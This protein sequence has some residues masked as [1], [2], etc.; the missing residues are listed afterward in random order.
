MDQLRGMDGS[1]F[2][3]LPSASFSPMPG[4]PP[5]SN[6]EFHDLPEAHINGAAASH[7]GERRR[8]EMLDIAAVLEERYR[9][10]LPPERRHI[11][12]TERLERE[13]RVV[14]GPSASAEP[15]GDLD[16]EIDGDVNPANLAAS[17]KQGDKL[18][19]TSA[20]SEILSTGS[21]KSVTPA[22]FTAPSRKR[23]PTAT[24]TVHKPPPTRRSVSHG[25][26]SPPLSSLHTFAVEPPL[27]TSPVQSSPIRMPQTEISLSASPASPPKAMNQRKQS[28]KAEAKR[29]NK[30]QKHGKEPEGHKPTA[31]SIESHGDE[32]E[33]KVTTEPATETEDDD[34]EMAP[35]SHES[36]NGALAELPTPTPE[37]Q[38]AS[39]P[40][41]DATDTAHTKRRKPS[42]VI[43]PET[44]STPIV[45]K[46]NRKQDRERNRNRN[47]NRSRACSLAAASP[48]PQPDSDM[49]F[50]ECLLMVAAKRQAAA[51][52]GRTAHR[53]ITAF[54]VKVPD[55]LSSDHMEFQLPWYVMPPQG[56]DPAYATMEPTPV[57]EPDTEAELNVVDDDETE[58]ESRGPDGRD[59]SQ[60]SEVAAATALLEL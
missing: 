60:D 27:P 26:D 2:L 5:D 36:H 16:G 22:S 33:P 4:V 49:D 24:N 43:I 18:K 12:R 34:V 58:D 11:E 8:K 23:K 1:A 45:R 9:V 14:V 30:R 25:H 15:E 31:N 50:D 20:I 48:H 55:T 40:P 10:L 46:R 6:V 38:L 51:P 41:E 56:D 32:T 17:N 37:P 19:L 42:A 53:H 35:P 52:R 54:G 3:A 47:R 59:E 39:E 28:K 13:K 7:E 44:I 21:Q 57:P 29:P